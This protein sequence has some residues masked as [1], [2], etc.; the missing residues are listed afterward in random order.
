MFF[1][2]KITG[3]KSLIPNSVTIL[4][5]RVVARSRSFDA[6]VVTSP[7]FSF[8]ETYPPR[9]EHNSSSN[10]VLEWRCLSSSGMN[11][12]EPKLM[13]RDMTEILRTLSQPGSM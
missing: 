4:R 3:P 10:F 8:S 11:Q 9:S 13:P 5:A 7:N 2:P 12:V 6:P 1:S